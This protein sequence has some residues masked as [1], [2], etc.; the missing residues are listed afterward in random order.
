M[1]R[2]VHAVARRVFKEPSASSFFASRP[3]PYKIMNFII[4]NVER[5]DQVKERATRAPVQRR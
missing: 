3:A 2:R 4:D 1:G 5:N